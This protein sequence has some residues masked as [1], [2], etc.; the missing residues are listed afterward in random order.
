MCHVD[1]P[2]VSS[3]GCQG[4]EMEC[5]DRA[6]TSERRIKNTSVLKSVCYNVRGEIMTTQL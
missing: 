3:C 1:S 5:V 6:I 2:Q 4:E